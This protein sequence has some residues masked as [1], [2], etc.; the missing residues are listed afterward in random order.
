MQIYT[1]LQFVSLFFRKR[2]W[3][4]EDIKRY[5]NRIIAYTVVTGGV[6]WLVSLPFA[7][8]ESWF[9]PGLLA[10]TAVSAVNFIFLAKAL[11]KALSMEKSEAK[12][13]VLKNYILRLFLFG[14]VFLLCARF[15][16]EAMI[17]SIAGFLTVKVAIYTDGW[18]NRER[19]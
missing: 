9:A 13:Y 15:G 3:S 1:D 10:G 2:I 4:M 19:S 12:K 11:E 7:G 18:V 14:T 16:M 6:F 8:V 17:G 5:R